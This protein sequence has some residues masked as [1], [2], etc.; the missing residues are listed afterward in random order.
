MNKKT[1]ISCIVTIVV[2]MT[3]VYSIALISEVSLLWRSEKKVVK[4]EL[5]KKIYNRFHTIATLEKRIQKDPQDY[6]AHIKLAQKY[7]EIQEYDSANVYFQT[8]LKISERSNFSL[9]SYSMFC[10]ERKLYNLALNL[11]EEISLYNKKAILYKAKIYESIAKSLDD[12]NEIEGSI[13]AY[14]VA[15]KYAKG[16]Y[17]KE[18]FEKLKTNYAKEYIKMA[19]IKIARKETKKAI[20]D[21]NN[22]LKI[23][24]T[25]I[26]QY[27]LA[28]I[29][30]DTNKVRAE[31]LIKKVLDTNPY[32]VNP[33]IYND[34][35]NNILEEARLLGNTNRINYYNNK[36]TSFNKFLNKIYI[37]KN[38]V[39]ISSIQILPKK[40][41]F[42]GKE[43]IFVKYNIENKTKTEINNLFMFTELY[44]GSRKIQFEN[45]IATKTSAFYSGSTKTII[46]KL[47]PDITEDN[48]VLTNDII[49]KFYAKRQKKAPWTLIK[50]QQLK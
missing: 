8:A 21:I 33:Y 12:D 26:A 15:Y 3:I 7:N 40:K 35:L 27:K 44:L 38:D 14:Q 16:V 41:I 5:S 2:T 22:S 47:P 18:D 45:S 43:E 49:I 25:P 19:D 37:F 36:I 48:I 50:I 30:K 20:L 17:S 9:Y 10:I 24:E 46:N 32:V 34:L 31:K 39:K 11:A 4:I 6:K 28:L 1:L 42:F 29:Y 23:K 13:R